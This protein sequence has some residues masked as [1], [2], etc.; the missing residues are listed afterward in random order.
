[1]VGIRDFERSSTRKVHLMPSWGVQFVSPGRS[2]G[3]L[4]IALTGQ[5]KE[6]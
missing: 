6:R 1:V 5:A 2:P 4:K 3:V